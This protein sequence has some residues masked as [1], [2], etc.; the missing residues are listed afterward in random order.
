MSQTPRIDE[1]C[2]KRNCGYWGIPY[3][4]ACQLEREVK[5]LEHDIELQ[6]KQ[7]SE[8]WVKSASI[9]N[10]LSAMGTGLEPVPQELHDVPYVAMQ[11]IAN[12]IKSHE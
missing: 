8:C 2:K 4:F 6:N 9:A 12:W 3:D 5:A 11:K 1:I 10:K 7:L